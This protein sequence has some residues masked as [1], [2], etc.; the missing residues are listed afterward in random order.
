MRWGARTGAAEPRE[1]FPVSLEDVPRSEHD[2]GPEPQNTSRGS[3]DARPMRR[4]LALLFGGGRRADVVVECRRC[5]KTISRSI[6]HCPE[7]DS[8]STPVDRCPE[9]ESESIAAYEI[10]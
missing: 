4:L 1:G 9:C 3:R 7:C 5:G 2:P 8:G 10:G 6:E